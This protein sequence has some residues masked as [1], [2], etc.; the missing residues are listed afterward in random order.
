MHFAQDRLHAAVVDLEQVL[1]HEQRVLDLLAERVVLA[2]NRLDHGGLAARAEQV[3]HVGRDFD[4]AEPR[5]FQRRGFLR[6]A[7]DERIE[8][9]ERRLGHL[10]EPRD[11]H[12]D[13]GLLLLLEPLE[14]VCGLLARQVRENRRDDLRVLVLDDLRDA[15]AD[16]ST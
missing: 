13:L 1:E 9:L 3:D 11:A 14:H 15:C 6:L 10:V 16:P 12:R 5:G 8:L 4:A 7:L 2:L